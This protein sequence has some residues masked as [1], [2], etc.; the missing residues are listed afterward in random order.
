MLG[1]L[2]V[3]LVGVL[4]L[5]VLNGFS[6]LMSVVVCLVVLFYMVLLGFV[7]IVRFCN[8]CMVVM[9]WLNFVLGLV[10]LYFGNLLWW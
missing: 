9:N 1:R 10:G 8:W 7:V 2:G 3:C 6:N 4:F 5:L